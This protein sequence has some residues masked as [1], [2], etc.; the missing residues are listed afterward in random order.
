[1]ARCIARDAAPWL[2]PDSE[3]DRLR[4]GG[5]GLGD[6]CAQKEQ[7]SILILG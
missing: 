5:G 2:A 7:S 1:M 4:K 6:P 3:P